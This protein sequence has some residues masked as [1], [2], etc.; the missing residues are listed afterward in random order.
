MGC[1]YSFD[2]LWTIATSYLKNGEEQCSN[3]N[4]DKKNANNC[5]SINRNNDKAMLFPWRSKKVDDDNDE[6]SKELHDWLEEND[7][8]QFTEYF[9]DIG[10]FFIN[11]YFIFH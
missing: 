11:Y 7:L 5:N 1:V 10:K 3:K 4:I 6:I 9:T 8:L 2:L